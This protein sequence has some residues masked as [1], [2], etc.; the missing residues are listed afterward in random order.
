MSCRADAGGYLQRL[1]QNLVELQNTQLM[2]ENCLVEWES[3]HPSG[4]GF[5]LL[6]A[7]THTCESV[8]FISI[9]NEAQAPTIQSSDGTRRPMGTFLY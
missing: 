7:N 4:R 5:R 9:K 3:S 8:D 6:Q 1:Y 2:L